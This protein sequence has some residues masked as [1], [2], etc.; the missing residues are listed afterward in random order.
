MRANKSITSSKRIRTRYGLGL[1]AVAIIIL[2]STLANLIFGPSEILSD[3]IFIPSNL[4][5]QTQIALN[6][7]TKPITRPSI[8]YPCGERNRI[9]LREKISIIEKIDFEQAEQ[10]LSQIWSDYSN[11]SS[12]ASCKTFPEILDAAYLLQQLVS[13]NP[14]TPIQTL[15][16][17][18]F[19]QNLNWNLQAF[20]VYGKDGLGKFIVSGR[21]GNCGT[22]EIKSNAINLARSNLKLNVEPL[23]QLARYRKENTSQGGNKDLTL[24]INP[25]LQLLASNISRCTEQSQLCNSELLSLLKLSSDLTFTILNAN[26]GAVL[27]VGCHGKSCQKSAN[28]QLGLLAGANIE[29]PPASTEKL[30]FSYS[31]LQAH[32]AN[33]DELQFQIKTSGEI[34]GKVSKRNEWWEKGA[35]CNNQQDKRKCAVPY[36]VVEFSKDIGLNANCSKIPN[37]QCGTSQLLDSIGLGQFGPINGRILVSS[38]KEGPFLDENALKGPYMSWNDYDDIR[39][40]KKKANNYRLLENTSLAVQSVIGASNNRITSFG[41]A[42]IAAS[43]YQ[44]ASF[45]HVKEAILFETKNTNIKQI[46]GQKNAQIILKGMQKVVMPSEKNWTGDGTASKVFSYAFGKQCINN[47]PVYAKTGTVSKQDTVY[48]GNTLFT[49]IVKTNELQQLT[50]HAVTVGPEHTLAIGVIANPINLNTG[51]IASKFGMLLIKEI[52]QSNGLQ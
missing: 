2:L 3:G 30:L 19:T 35:I 20:C 11:D 37:R 1:F 27:A 15:V 17:Q 38:N 41:L 9:L 49:A 43:L 52:I 28:K 6:A 12:A 25:E 7:I 13:A 32:T 46:S 26:T 34:D 23:L 16:T 50:D 47:C 48:G 36:G 4:V 40:G 45:S 29:S 24:T 51:H 21:P 5:N 10:R 39:E 18:I 33:P 8:T 42:T 31:F 14:K 44:I 22:E